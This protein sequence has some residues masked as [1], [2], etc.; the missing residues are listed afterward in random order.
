MQKYFINKNIFIALIIFST[1]SI[2]IAY[3]CVNVGKTAH[4]IQI[5]SLEGNWQIV[6]VGSGACICPAIVFYATGRGEIYNGD[7]LNKR[8]LEE[9]TWIQ[10]GNIL[11]ITPT[12]N[13]YTPKNGRLLY[14]TL[15]RIKAFK[16]KSER[17]NYTEV[18]IIPTNN[19]GIEITFGG[20]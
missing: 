1:I 18:S 9:F 12:I 7:V 17:G 6:K 13:E 11:K 14:S 5:K 8:V 10:K 16:K 15:Y 4:R 20:K 19:T 2:L 3:G